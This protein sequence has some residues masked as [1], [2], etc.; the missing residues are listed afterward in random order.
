MT[1]T[2]QKI[3]TLIILISF[4]ITA[5]ASTA[6]E[7]NQKA[8]IGGVGGATA[9]GLIAAAF[10]ANT[11]GVLGGIVLGGLIGGAI[12]DRMDAAD[13]REASLATHS[14]LETAPSGTSTGWHNPDSGNSGTIT[15]TRTYQAQNGEYCREYEHTVTISGES[16]QAYGTACRQ[17]D[18]SWQVLQ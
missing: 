1:A 18:G 12:G 8:I 11:A 16:K 14:A 17:A 7:D 13:R 9:G 2:F 15:P 6:W 5:C 10:D 3:S 4:V